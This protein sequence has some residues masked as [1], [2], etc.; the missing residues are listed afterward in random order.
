MLIILIINSCYVHVINVIYSGQ[1]LFK[2]FYLI[3]LNKRGN[4]TFK[5]VYPKFLQSLL[6][7][8]HQQN[9]HTFLRPI[10]AYIR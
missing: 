4:T 8:L 10:H 6:K 1:L 7:R 5:L 3:K 2:Y 9:S